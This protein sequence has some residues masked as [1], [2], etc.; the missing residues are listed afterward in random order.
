MSRRLYLILIPAL[1]LFACSGQPE[2][3][4][5]ESPPQAGTP[6]Q[7][8]QDPDKEPTSAQAEQTVTAEPVEASTPTIPET[9]SGEA[10][11][12]FSGQPLPV[13]R[14]E[15]FSGAGACSICHSGM[16]DDSGRDV[17]IDTYWRA[18]MM[19]NAARDPYWQA[20][21][22]A[23][24]MN[25]PGLAEVV[26]DKCS[27]CHMPMARTSVLFDGKQGLMLDD[28]F[29]DT[30]HPLHNLAMDGVSCTLC[31]QIEP[32][33]LGEEI[34]FSGGFAVNSELPQGERLNYGPYEVIEAQAVV[35][36]AASGYIPV[37]GMHL[38]E[39]E[40]CAT[41]HTLYTPTIN[42][43]GEITGTFPEQMVYFEWLNSDYAQEKS[44]QDCHMPVAEGGVQISITG[45]EPRSP[46]S[47]HEFVGGNTFIL[48]ML[49]N[50]GLEI[51]VTSSSAQLEAS[52]ERAKA[53]LEERTA[54]ISIESAEITDGVLS[55]EVKINNQ[56]GHKFPT[57]FPSRRAWLHVLISNKDNTVIFESGAVETDGR[58][59]GNA[60]DEDASKF[61]QHYQQINDPQQ[62]QI[63]ESIL[64]TGSG[65]VT[66]QLL[67]GSTY[68]KDN[69]LLP[70]GFEK[71]TDN[72]D[73]AVKGEAQ[74]DPNFRGGEDT[75][76][77]SIEVDPEEGPFSLIVQ[78]YYQ[79][80]GT[81]WAVNLGDH[82]APEIERFLGYYAGMENLPVV[83]SQAGIE[84]K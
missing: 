84:V 16:N 60:N 1:L 67:R 68:L 73:I 2:S 43:A 35:M 25:N 15:Y 80:I 29:L 46:F 48:E 49:H 50:F 24:V 42:E 33:G 12:V 41:C 59:S 18:T 19:A 40:V 32:D 78:L 83:I 77:Y 45:G 66:T 64:G 63:Y 55:F 11:I 61:E 17:S 81:R 28:G 20:T 6:S 36:Q 30:A 14:G 31:H 56:S 44:C 22:R 37:Q 5:E 52:Q 51:G 57:G 58:I 13:D 76:G 79:A 27:T 26:E 54:N 4:T 38:Q 34:S 21:V 69:R 8:V 71:N 82:S 3:P 47:I 74:T 53:Q 39:A 10:P 9:T 7:T 72:A 62:V 65:S 23:E 70:A 75:V